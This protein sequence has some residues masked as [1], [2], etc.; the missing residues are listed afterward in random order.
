[1]FLDLLP[2]RFRPYAKAV[3]ASLATVLG[4]L[5]TAGITGALDRG[6]LAVAVVG[7][8]TTALVYGA[9]NES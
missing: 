8:I 1:M 9:P 6:A 5:A 7:L 2:A 4:T 3:A